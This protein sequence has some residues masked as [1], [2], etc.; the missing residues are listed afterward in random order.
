MISF[1]K[2]VIAYYNLPSLPIKEWDSK[3][4]F[5]DGVAIVNLIDDTQAYAACTFDKDTDK[6]PR[7]T[8]TFS[9]TPFKSIEKVFV[10][11]A[12]MDNDVSDADLDKESKKRAEELPW[13]PSG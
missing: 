9:C 11:P 5:K 6:A 4:S 8:K 13:W 1:E 12:Y 10:V 7:I 3:S 2:E